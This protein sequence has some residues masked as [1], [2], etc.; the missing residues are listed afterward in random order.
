MLRRLWCVPTLLCFILS[1][2]SLPQRAAAQN[3]ADLPVP[4]AMVHL[5]VGYTPLLLRGLK[6]HPDNPLL[7]DFIVDTGNDSPAS[8]KSQS[9][10]LIKYF[11]ASLTVPESEQWVNLSPYEKQRI[12][13]EVMG[14]T[15][16]G[17]DMLVEDYILKQLTASLAYPES[18]LGRDFWDTI[19]AKASRLYGTTQIPVNTFNKV[20]IVADKAKVYVYD[21]AAYVVAAHLKVMLDEDYLAMQKNQKPAAQSGIYAQMVRKLILPEIEKEV[22]TGKNFTALRQIFYSMI[23]A[24]WYKRNLKEVLLNQVYTDKSKIKGVDIKDKRVKEEIYQ[25]YLK[26]YKKGV[27]NYIKEDIDTTSGQNIPRK[28]FSGGL[29]QMDM[30][31]VVDRNDPDLAVF[32]G[33][34]QKGGLFEVD[35]SMNAEHDDLWEPINVQRSVMSQLRHLRRNVYLRENG[36]FENEMA[37]HYAKTFV[38][39]MLSNNSLEMQESLRHYDM[40]AYVAQYF[41]RHWDQRTRPSNQDI[42]TDSIKE[43]LEEERKTFKEEKVLSDAGIFQMGT[44]MLGSVSVNKFLPL[45]ENISLYSRSL[46]EELAKQWESNSQRYKG[47]KMSLVKGDVSSGEDLKTAMKDFKINAGLD[48]ADGG[49]HRHLFALHFAENPK[50]P[51]ISIQDILNLMT[52]LQTVQEEGIGNFIFVS[53]VLVHYG[54]KKQP[55]AFRKYIEEK[56]VRMFCEAHGIKYV[57]LRLPNVAGSFRV[58]KIRRGDQHKRVIASMVEEGEDFRMWDA[59][60]EIAPIGLD[61]ATDAI[62]KAAVY[63]RNGNPSTTIDLAGKE[64][65]TLKQI[66]DLFNNIED[67]MEN[68]KT[69]NELIFQPY[70]YNRLAQ[71]LKLHWHAKASIAQILQQVILVKMSPKKPVMPSSTIA[72]KKPTEAELLEKLK[73]ALSE[74]INKGF[75]SQESALECMTGILMYSI[76]QNTMAFKIFEKALQGFDPDKELNFN[77]RLFGTRSFVKALADYGEHLEDHRTEPLSKEQYQWVLEIGEKYLERNHAMISQI[78]TMVPNPP[79]GIDLN[80]QNLRMDVTQDEHGMTMHFDPAMLEEFKKGDFSGISPVILRITPISDILPLLGI[81]K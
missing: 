64:K 39:Q 44:G 57:I 33:Q 25:Q 45:V 81:K 79:G 24:T 15:E 1:T 66:Q 13:P 63:L 26:A 72:P 59:N 3:L 5:S 35:A 7:F 77:E 38:Q 36:D 2:L 49:I 47:K 62:V 22:N 42:I 65:M 28:Y 80:G 12:I 31:Q 68:G 48:P 21:N 61:D 75:F 41:K 55:Y 9:I 67:L 71:N 10:R 40:Y 11:L 30:A 19:Y 74:G 32:I 53:S 51:Y 70:D 34:P 6:V 16:L 29:T 18:G 78:S 52:V 58:G 60:A 23:L 43:A 50:S 69:I 14:Q 27:F 20:W 54:I 76:P 56:I 73:Q 46:D 37:L 17:R 8:L 4:G